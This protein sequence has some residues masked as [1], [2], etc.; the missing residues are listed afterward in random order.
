MLPKKKGG[1][2]EGKPAAS[3]G[4]KIFARPRLPRSEREAFYYWGFP[5]PPNFVFRFAKCGVKNFVD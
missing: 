5:P 3:D 1:G 4:V 2:A